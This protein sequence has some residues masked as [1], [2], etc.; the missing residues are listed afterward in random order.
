LLIFVVI[1]NADIFTHLIMNL[2]NTFD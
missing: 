1:R 2:W